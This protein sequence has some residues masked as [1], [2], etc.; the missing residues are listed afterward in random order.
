[1]MDQTSYPIRKRDRAITDTDRI[2]EWKSR[3]IERLEEYEAY[4]KSLEKQRMTPPGPPSIPEDELGITPSQQRLIRDMV[5][6]Y[7]DGAPEGVDEIVMDRFTRGEAYAYIDRLEKLGYRTRKER[8]LPYAEDP[9]LLL[10][11]LQSD[12]VDLRYL[13]PWDSPVHQAWESDQMPFRAADAGMSLEDYLAHERRL[14]NEDDD[15][16]DNSDG[17]TEA[18]K[19]YLRDLL[20]GGALNPKDALSD[21]NQLAGAIDSLTASEAELKIGLLQDLGYFTPEEHVKVAENLAKLSAST[22]RASKSR[23]STSP[24]KSHGRTPRGR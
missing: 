9:P 3:N 21:T 16:Q 19:Q 7:D 20:E 2:A 12:D 11:A 4:R 14:D 18:Q 23:K 17:A 10:G 1:M 24:L 22:R 8:E 6:Y 5:S 15:N 13:L